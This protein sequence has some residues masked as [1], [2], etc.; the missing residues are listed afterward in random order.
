MFNGQTIYV[1]KWLKAKISYQSLSYSLFWLE[2]QGILA[3]IFTLFK[4][5]LMVYQQCL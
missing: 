4:V 1:L 2:Y 3:L 5:W